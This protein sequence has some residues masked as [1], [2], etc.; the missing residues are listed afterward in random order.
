V[1]ISIRRLFTWK[2]V[3]YDLLLPAL[4]RLEPLRGDRALCSLG[5]I[6]ATVW[7]GR[8]Q[9]LERALCH[10]RDALSLDG[11]VESLWPELAAGTARFLARD[12][13]LDVASDGEALSRFEVHGLAPLRR[14][15]ETGRGVMLVGNHFGAY[16]P[17]LHWLFRS[18]LPISAL[19]QR[20]PHISG[21]LSRMFDSRLAMGAEHDL[22]LRRNLPPGAAVELLL[23]A[24]AALR[25]GRAVYT[26]GDIPWHGPNTQPGRLLGRSHR[27][28]SIW[29][30][31][32]A[33][34]RAPTFHVF[35]SHRPGGR[36][37]LELEAVGQIHAGEEALAVADFLGELE[38]RIAND[39]SQAVA[40]LLWPCFNPTAAAVSPEW[41]SEQRAS[42]LRRPS[43]RIS[44]PE[45]R[46]AD[47][48]Y[49]RP[50]ESS[51]R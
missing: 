20:P 36:F 26:C 1:K 38:A 39:P 9:R 4:R 18:G 31:L 19:V 46:A 23:R 44:G 41:R 14:A 48:Y 27:F 5:R 10:A 6:I 2:F 15:I 51:I 49:S 32:A 25:N 34:T 8:R 12:Y 40:H 35:C 7:P 11:P 45:C 28:L 30:E 43:R 17:G 21:E 3:F 22:F 50:S 24:R 16:L 47:V 29:A 13:L 33:L 37:R 42:V